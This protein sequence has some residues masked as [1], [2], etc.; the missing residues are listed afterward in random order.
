MKNSSS[1][2]IPISNATGKSAKAVLLKKPLVS[3]KSPKVAKAK[4]ATHSHKHEVVKI[5]KESAVINQTKKASLDIAKQVII[6]RNPLG[7]LLIEKMFRE[8]GFRGGISSDKRILEKYSTDESIFSIRPQVVIQP[9]N[10]QDVEIAVKVIARETKRFTSLS[11]TPRAAGTGLSGGSL[12]DSIV[13]DVCTHLHKIGEV[14]ETKDEIYFT[15]E[16]GAMW[17]D[18]EKKLK[19]HGA[20]LPPY[21]S[22]KDIC[23]I[24][25]S[26]ANNAAGPD[27][28]RYGHCA[29]WVKS[30]DVVLSD[31]ITYTI[32]PLTLKEF[33]SL[34]REKNEYARIAREI[35]SLIEKNEKIILA[36][37]PKT[38]KNTAGYSL[39][40]VFSDGVAAFKKGKGTFDLTRLISGSQGSIGIVTNITMRA[41]PIQKDTTLLVVP[42]FDLE[43]SAKVITRALKFNPINIELFDALSF[44]LALKNPDFFKKRLSGIDYYRTML[45]MYATYHIRYGRKTPEF[46][47]LITLD[48][49]TVD[50]TPRAEIV[51]E[52]STLKT[53]ARVVTNKVEQ[54]MLWQIRRASFTLSKFQ[55]P[56]KRPAAFLE[57]MTVPPESLSK[58]FIEVKRLLKEFNVTAAVHG[59]GGNGHFHF[60]PLLDFTNKTTPLLVEK[61]AEKFYST[62]VKFKGDFCGE[63]NDGIIRTPYLNK[64]FSKQVL[65]LFKKTEHIFDPDDIFNPGKKVNPRFDIKAT[66]RKTN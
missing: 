10:K 66:M 9:K 41:L 3:K 55:D 40:H 45:N 22:S 50:K 35:F 32:K 46:T 28:L 5:K 53:R 24:G 23:S 44:D 33:K 17:R 59:H 49:E 51:K 58:F 64:M 13:L 34:S 61:M 39:W 63:H 47:V 60:Y 25:G 54:E 19:H 29:D 30:L 11:L 7:H 52:I 38:K 27:S 1:F 8:S 62:A 48:K 2:S 20:Y 15:C 4:K 31:G 42:I 14:V 26:V 12:T 16:P 57:D 37:K 56:N 18:V 21:T 65:E 6:K 36:G 43:E